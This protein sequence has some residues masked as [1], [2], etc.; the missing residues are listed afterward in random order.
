M[1]SP[2]LHDVYLLTGSNLGDRR[3]Q[4]VLAVAEMEQ[5]AGSIV[6]TS[7]IYETEAWGLEGLP[8][9]LNQALL[10][11]TKLEPLPLLYVLQEIE[12]RLGRVRQQRWGVRAIDIDI[13]YYDDLVLNLPQLSIPHPLMQ[14]RNFV[15]APLAELA[16]D[17]MHPVLHQTNAALLQQSADKL[18]VWPCDDTANAASGL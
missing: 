2:Q 18:S 11:R 1:S 7:R 14:E 12:H 8:A 3:E 9:H 10:L 15:L 5:H 13:I 17:G 6:R 16:P 4:L